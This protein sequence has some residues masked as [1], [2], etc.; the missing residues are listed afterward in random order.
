MQF[1][2]DILVAAPGDSR[3]LLIVEAKLQPARSG[4]LSSALKQ[5]MLSMRV[6]TGLLVTRDSVSIL[7]DTFEGE[8]ESSIREVAEVPTRTIPELQPSLARAELSGAEF[9]DAVQ[10]WLVQLRNRLVHGYARGT[11]PIFAE[12]IMPALA[13]GEIRAGGP[14]MPRRAA[15]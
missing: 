4:D 6:P 5:Y 2:P 3:V 9:E 8:S 12:H 14:R 7:R 1:Q 10:S 11:D 15:G 13:A